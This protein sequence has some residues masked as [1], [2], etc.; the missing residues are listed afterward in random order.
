MQ[1]LHPPPSSSH[2]LFQHQMK[3]TM[4][5]LQEKVP[6]FLI[7]QGTSTIQ[8]LFKLVGYIG[9][10]GTHT[11][12]ANASDLS[13]VHNLGLTPDVLEY[14]LSCD[15]LNTPAEFIERYCSPPHVVLD[16]GELMLLTVD[17]T[18]CHTT[19]IFSILQKLFGPVQYGCSL[20][21]TDQPPVPILYYVC[22]LCLCSTFHDTSFWPHTHTTCRRVTFHLLGAWPG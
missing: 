12:T 5:S 9:H 7:Q 18:Q 6:Q 14:F 11:L 22:L 21:I 20:M 17:V 15:D 2:N 3:S 10:G 13:T 8:T 4:D 19:R 1:C 16:S